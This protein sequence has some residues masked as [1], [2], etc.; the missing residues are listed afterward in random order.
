MNETNPENTEF[1]LPIVCP[2]CSKELNVAMIFALLAP[3]ALKDS[4]NDRDDDYSDE[5]ESD[6]P[7]PEAGEEA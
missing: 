3:E 5:E 6:M 2:H 7:P 4:V 1:V